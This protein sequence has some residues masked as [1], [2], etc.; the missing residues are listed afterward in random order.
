LEWAKNGAQAVRAGGDISDVR[1][2]DDGGPIS[3][4]HIRALTFTMDAE[5]HD[6]L[7]GSNYVTALVRQG[8]NIFGASTPEDP[9]LSREDGTGEFTVAQLF[10][11]RYQNLAEQWSLNFSTAGQLASTALLA[12]E[13][14]YL[15]GP[16]FGRAYDSGKISGEIFRLYKDKADLEAKGKAFQAEV[17]KAGIKL[18]TT[19]AKMEVR[20]V[21]SAFD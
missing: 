4:D 9:F 6:S 12:P 21:D 10:Y 14:F 17:A 1:E 18:G 20:E 11:T 8:L 19:V 13:E 15:G 2:S 16:I 7:Q 3:D 5:L